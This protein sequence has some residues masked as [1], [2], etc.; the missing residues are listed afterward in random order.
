MAG[1]PALLQTKL[2]RVRGPNK[3]PTKERITIRLSPDVLQSF[4]DS[5]EGWQ[6]RIDLA[7]KDWLK[8]HTP[9]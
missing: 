3:A 6:S 5:G 4:R 9:A 8:S 7:L 2:R 1:L